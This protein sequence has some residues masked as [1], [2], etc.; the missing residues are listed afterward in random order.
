MLYIRRPHLLLH[1]LLHLQLYKLPY[2]IQLRR[3]AL[4]LNYRRLR[5]LHNIPMPV[6]QVVGQIR[7][8]LRRNKACP[9]GIRP[10]ASAF[11]DEIRPIPDE[12]VFLR[13]A[14]FVHPKA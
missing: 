3:F 5:Q 10:R 2:P 14:G 8:I 13:T 6:E 1:Q 12:I 9:A 11:V 7:I 4:Q